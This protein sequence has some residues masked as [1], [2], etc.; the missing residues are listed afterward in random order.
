MNLLMI[1]NGKIT[2]L[3]QLLDDPNLI[4]SSIAEVDEHADYQ[5]LHGATISDLSATEHVSQD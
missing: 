4:E 3:S 1:A 2:R 5:L